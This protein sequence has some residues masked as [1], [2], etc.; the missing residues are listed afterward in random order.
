[1]RFWR[2]KRSVPE[3]NVYRDVIEEAIG[4]QR[5]SNENIEKLIAERRLM[6]LAILASI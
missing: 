6:L 4:G 3:F 2:R 5:V 1:M